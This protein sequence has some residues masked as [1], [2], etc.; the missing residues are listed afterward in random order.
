MILVCDPIH[1]SHLKSTLTLCDCVGERLTLEVALRYWSC[2]YIKISIFGSKVP[3]CF[4]RTE[5]W[6]IRWIGTSM[7]FSLFGSRLGLL[8]LRDCKGACLWR[9]LCA[10][11]LWVNSGG[12]VR[13]NIYRLRLDLVV[14]Q[15]CYNATFRNQNLCCGNLFL[16]KNDETKNSGL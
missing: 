14:K 9:R 15:L 5:K 4:V 2:I 6:Q 7:I 11:I 12:G 3:F 16:H 8:H 1:I 10:W 13:S